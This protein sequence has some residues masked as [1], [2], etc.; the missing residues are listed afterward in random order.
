MHVFPLLSSLIF[1]PLLGGLAALAFADRP[2]QARLLCLLTALAELA[3]ALLIP[4][5]FASGGG[6]DLVEDYGWIAPLHVRYSLGM[7]GLS[8]VLTLLTAFLGVLGILTSWR[9]IKEG[10]AAFYV[11]LLAA[12][13]TAI[14]VF[15]ARDLLLFYLFWEAQLIP[16][17]FLIGRYGHENRRHAAVKFFLFSMVGGLPMLLAV[18]ALM[19]AGQDL[20]LA[21]LAASPVG[22]AMQGWCAAAFLLAFAVKTPIVPVHTWLPEAHTQ[23]PTA[24]SL[25]LAGVLLKTGAYAI[26][27]W[28]FPLFPQASATAAP[29]L[30][31]LGLVGLFHASWTALAQRDAKRLVAYSSIAHM[32]LILFAL[33]AHDR[34]GLSGAVVQMVSHALTTGALFV[35]VGM[36]AERFHSRALADFGGLWKRMPVYGAFLLFFAMASAG[37]PGLSNFVGELLILVGSFRVYPAA[38]CL[39]FGGIVVGLAYLLRMLQGTIFGPEGPLAIGPQNDPAGEHAGTYSPP[40][41]LSA[42]EVVVLTAFALAV[43]L[44]GLHPAPLLDMVREPLDAL[45]AGWPR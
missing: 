26:L 33:S 44:V 38:T 2:A 15:L 28:A 4:L 35:M 11:L 27:R 32:G 1:L 25:L 9:E 24:G 17:F 36:L 16:M 30:G 40:A 7:D 3:L 6:L 19:L 45:A 22:G 42:R 41:D 5:L 10:A 39:A 13:S 12:L 14:G 23:A 37:L 8:Y 18:I 29:W 20:S 43:L 21:A 31:G 34:I